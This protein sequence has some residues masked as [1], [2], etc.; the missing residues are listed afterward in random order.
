MTEQRK[1]RGR[2]LDY[3]MKFRTSRWAEDLVVNGLVENG[4]GIARLGLSHSSSDGTVGEQDIKYKEPDL[5]VLPARDFAEKQYDFSNVDFR[6]P[7]RLSSV[8]ELAG[9]AIGAIEVE[10]SPYRASLMKDR[11]W[12]PRDRSFYE[13]RRIPR[14]ARIPIAPN[15]WIKQED[16]PRLSAWQGDF[17]CP[18]AVVHVFD[19]EA[20]FVL[21]QSILE[22]DKRMG[23]VGSA[24]AV[25][26]QL[27]TGIFRKLQ[28]YDR[29]DAQGA[30]EEKLVWVVSPAAASKFADVRNVHVKAQLGASASEKYVAHPI[31]E[32]GEIELT[33]EARSILGNRFGRDT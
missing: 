2:G 13:K 18:I 10:F 22:A 5:L 26:M 20:F 9:L 17:Q 15:I 24:D 28:R 4:F 32:G 1:P 6:D 14:E 8:R 29:S 25:R 19:Q 7:T 33:G 27:E 3:E 12:R 23:K 30:A 21:L 16:I 11:H 31:F